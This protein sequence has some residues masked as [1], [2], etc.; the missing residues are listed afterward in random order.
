M[1]QVTLSDEV[2]KDIAETLNAGNNCWYHIRPARFYGHAIQTVTLNSMII[3]FGEMFI[4]KSRKR[5]MNV[6]HSNVWNHMNHLR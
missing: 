3:I 6:F 5:N 1:K 4:R 2:I